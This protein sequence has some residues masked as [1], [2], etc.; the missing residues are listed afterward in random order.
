[1]NRGSPGDASSSESSL[2]MSS[3]KLR[4]CK[5]RKYMDC[6]KCF[7]RS[8][9]YVALTL[10]VLK[11]PLLIVA[12]PLVYLHLSSEIRIYATVLFLATWLQM[13]LTFLLAQEYQASGD[14]LRLWINHKSL[15]FFEVHSKCC[16][17][18]GPDDYK[19]KEMKIPRSCYKGGSLRQEDLYQAGCSTRSIKP[20]IVPIP[21]VISVIF[22]YV[23]V[24]AIVIY[25][26][27]MI[28]NRAHRRTVWSV[29]RTELFG[30]AEAAELR[31]NPED[32]K[33]SE[34]EGYF[35]VPR[36]I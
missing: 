17:V 2:N 19:L 5:L 26:V 14:V 6:W 11:I 35:T 16:G 30:S 25:L 9:M 29:R 32:S 34:L 28:R 20:P 33:R 18:V 24:L 10:S 12:L 3:R 4:I 22:Q 23:L 21:Q 36:R 31:T 8:Y 1:M 27:I 7:F 15:E 13:M